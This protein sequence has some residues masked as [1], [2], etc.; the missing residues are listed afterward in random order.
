MNRKEFLAAL[1]KRLYPTL[2]AE[3]FRGSGATLRRIGEPMVHV[4]NVQGSTTGKHCYLNLGAHLSFLPA[5]GGQSV[6]P[7]KL[8]ESHCVFRGRMEPPP[9]PA[10]GWPYGQ[11]RDEMNEV[12]DFVVDHWRTEAG[13]FYSQY[14]LYPDSF[15]T[16]VVEGLKKDIHP[17]QCLTL[18]RIARELN[19]RDEVSQLAEKGLATCSEAAWGLRG[20]LRK[21]LE[22]ELSPSQRACAR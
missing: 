4:F 2:R 11:N 6:T 7:D 18:S 3:G 19:L 15:I 14:A 20:N 22:V 13:A 17:Y 8:Q 9:G 5:E 12:I 21:M 16:L 10:F 1:S